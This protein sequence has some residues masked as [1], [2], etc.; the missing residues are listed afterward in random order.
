M[1]QSEASAATTGVAADVAVTD[2]R[3]PAAGAR[4]IDDARRSITFRVPELASWRVRI[5]FLVY[6]EIDDESGF[7]RRDETGS[8]VYEYLPVGHE[9]VRPI[10][11]AN[12]NAEPE[13]IGREYRRV[14]AKLK[15]N[16]ELYQLHAELLLRHDNGRLVEVR[17]ALREGKAHKYLPL[18]VAEF[19]LR[20][21]SPS[22]ISDMADA[23]HVHRTTIYRALQ[24]ADRAGLITTGELEQRKQPTP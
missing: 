20:E 2:L 8:V 16:L 18:V 9:L 1:T 11:I 24:D 12:A 10:S 7:W 15:A 22:R 14:S 23:F 5:D 17:N 19:R 13:T 3:G 4:D 6:V 21:D